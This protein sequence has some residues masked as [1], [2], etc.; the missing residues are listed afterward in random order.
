MEKKRARDRQTDP[1]APPTTDRHK[2]PRDSQLRGGGVL[3]HCQEI[4]CPHRLLEGEYNSKTQRGA[5]RG[6]W[7][8]RR[9]YQI[10]RTTGEIVRLQ[11]RQGRAS[12]RHR[13][14]G[15]W[16]EEEE[17]RKRLSDDGGAQSE[18]TSEPHAH[19][20]TQRQNSS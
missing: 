17:K 8:N 14:I 13:G 7:R 12:R 4:A 19:K 11:I 16:E 2:R 20:A 10:I 18:G 1:L 6:R 9:G 3:A 15:M 5:R